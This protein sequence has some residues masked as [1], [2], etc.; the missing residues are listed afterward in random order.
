MD[1]FARHLLVALL[2]QFAI[3]NCCA[4][5][6][7]QT[8]TAFVSYVCRHKSCDDV[9]KVLRPLLPGPTDNQTNDAGIQLVVDRDQNRL[10]ISGPKYVHNIAK[11]LV[12]EVDQ[13]SAVAP[14][15]T[16]EL[17]VRTY[18][19]PARL[20]QTFARQLKSKIGNALRLSSDADSGRVFVSASKEAHSLVAQTAASLTGELQ[21]DLPTL[22]PITYREAP[23]PQAVP[24]SQGAPATQATTPTY[25]V[26]SASAERDNAGKHPRFIRVP[27]GQIDRVQ[28][29][30]MAIF[31]TRL[32][33]NT[34]GERQVF[35]LTTSGKKPTRVEVEFDRMRSGVLVGGSDPALSQLTTLIESLF[36]ST[37]PGQGTKVFGLRRDNHQKL[38]EVIES[39]SR[40][41]RLRTQANNTSRVRR[42]PS[43]PSDPDGTI[44]PVQYLETEANRGPVLLAQATGT[45]VAPNNAPSSAIPQSAPGEVG[46]V[47]QF[48]GVD[49][50]SLP[51]LDVIILRGPDQDLDQLAEIIQQ[52]ELISQ[53]T[54]PEVRVYPLE[55]AQSEAIAEVVREVSEDLVS[56]RQGR[57]SVLP[58]VKPN[59]ILI[60]GWGDAVVATEELV[61]QLDRPVAPESQSEVFRLKHGSATQVQQTLQNFFQNRGG[62]GPRVQLATDQ[63]TNSLIVYAAPRD[64]E[65]IRK[66]IGDIDSAEGDAVNRAQV[67][68]IENALATDVAETLQQAIQGVGGDGERTA[69]LEL[70]DADGRRILRSGTL[71]NVQITPNARN[72]TLIISSPQGNLELIEALIRQ[73]DTPSG[74]AKIKVF[75]IVNGDAASLIQT[76]RSLIP[77]AAPGGA[78]GAS[79]LSATG[80]AGLAPLRFSLDARSNSIIA[81]GADGDLL[82]VEALLA[83]L[84]QTTTMQ[85]KTAVYRLRNSPAID[86]AN[87]VNQYLLSRRQLDSAVPGQSNAFAEIEREVVVVPEPIANKLI[88]AATP[89]YFEEIQALIEKLDESPPQVMIQVLIAEVTLDDADE[90]GIELGLQDS[91]LFDRSLLGDLLTTNVTENISTADGIVTTTQ[92]IIQAATNIPGLAFNS[93]GPLGNSGSS[94]SI[95]NADQIGSQGISNFS[96]GRTNEQ[97]GFGGLVLSASSR[98]LS[99]LLRALRESRRV[100]VLSRPQIR[101]LDNQPA[102]IQVG[103]R[104]PRIIGSTTNQFGTSNSVQLEDVGLILGVTPRVSPDGKVVME[105]DAEKSAVGSVN[106][107]IPISASLDGATVVRSPRVETTTAQATVAAADGETIVLGG[108]I[109]ENSEYVHRSVPFLGDIP[110]IEKLF[111]Y[112]SYT[113]RRSELLIILT[114]HVIRTPEDNERIKQVE[115]ARMSWCAC[116]VYKLMDDIGYVPEESFEHVDMGSPEV[117]YPDLNP[118]G[119]LDGVMMQGEVQ[120][121]TPPEPFS[122]EPLPGES[123]SGESFSGEPLIELAPQELMPANRIQVGGGQ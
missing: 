109:T 94:Q 59:S 97:L 83:K 15:G 84:D 14:Q 113:K 18:K 2:L 44:Q 80:E 103:E 86:I 88:L 55:Y 92:D 46:P 53:D 102:Y 117:I 56:G 34:R 105:I 67:F 85:R 60:I 110:L 50:E 1:G 65:E 122:G 104:V 74:Q 118:T 3:V 13:P 32:Q 36:R 73:L 93:T 48:E 82:I 112:D 75:R 64:L 37:T 43:F 17:T 115:M 95:N 54:Q 108:L 33:V 111:R 120:S 76:L 61:K 119:D 107:G 25:P 91:V 96:L 57:V 47:R 106:E 77:S 31:G 23:R 42:L 100:E 116:D 22:N 51:D 123:F 62:L 10:L 21:T 35:V 29:Q 12:S 19:I 66:L 20:H 79:Q 30:L 101:T 71:R 121:L 5:T 27:D 90:F 4:Q 45:P 8:P 39:G 72:N 28:Q 7:A 58:L 6:D 26:T 99:I 78:G 38:R 9:A 98:N 49:V 70:L 81:T 41:N 24:V 69:A 68:K 63:A 11:R 89:R 40:E 52:L 87:A 16:P 114:P